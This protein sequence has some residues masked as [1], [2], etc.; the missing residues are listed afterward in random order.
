MLQ[1]VEDSYRREKQFAA[2]VSHELR[3]PL[4]V[5]LAQCEYALCYGEEEKEEREALDTIFRQ[6][7]QMKNLV[8]NLLQLS[9]LEDK[10]G[11]ERKPLDASLFCREYLMDVESLFYEKG[12]RLRQEIEKDIWLLVQEDLFRTMLSNLVSNALKF[13]AARVTVSLKKE[14]EMILLS[15]WDDGAGFAPEEKDRIWDRLYQVDT[16]RN[17]KGE[18]GTG[19]GLSFVKQIAMLHGASVKAESE[20]GRFALFQIFFPS[21]SL[22][23]DPL[24]SET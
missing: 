19:L 21:S 17:K 18:S 20:K 1:R 13:A 7:R 5:I 22:H 8:E 24:Q 6:G 4:S 10:K 11:I 16:A 14:K 9:G 12:I 3:T 15:V 23:L 2:D